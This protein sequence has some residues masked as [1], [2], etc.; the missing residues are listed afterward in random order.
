MSRPI[1]IEH[2]EIAELRLTMKSFSFQIG[3]LYVFSRLH[4]FSS[5]PAIWVRYKDLFIE[6][7]GWTES[8]SC[9]NSI[10]LGNK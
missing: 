2:K 4:S 1:L 6:M 3:S 7:E 10:P 5:V 9:K 8:K